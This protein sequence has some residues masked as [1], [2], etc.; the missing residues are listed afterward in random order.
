MQKSNIID[1]KQYNHTLMLYINST[2][3]LYHELKSGILPLTD[4][5]EQINMNKKAIITTHKK[6]FN[7]WQ[8][9]KTGKWYS[10]LPKE[11]VKPPKGKQIESVSEEKLNDKIFDYYTKEEENKQKTCP[12][13]SDVYWKWRKIKDLELGGTSICGYNTNWKRCFEYTDFAEMEIDKINENTVRLFMLSRI[14]ELNLPKEACRKLFDV[15]KHVIRYARVEK[16]ILENPV[17]FLEN[18]DFTKL[19]TDKV[20]PENE[21][22]FNDAELSII[23]NALNAYH[24]ENPLNMSSYAIHLAVF[25][26]MRTGEL[27]TLKWSDIENGC[28]S[29]NKSCKY[30]SLTH[31]FSVGDTKTKKSRKYPLDNQTKSLFE[32]IK[33]VQMQH[34]ILCEW[35]FT[36]GKG[37]YIHTHSV[38]DLMNKLCKR[39]N[40]NGGGVTK[41]RK[42]TSSNLQS[43]GVPKTV[44]ASMLGHTTDVNELYYTYDTSNLDEKKQVVE[45]RNSKFQ[46]MAMAI[47]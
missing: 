33:K 42:T 1:I 17:E 2:K 3:L 10:Y 29:I 30:N 20:K 47:G 44:V 21:C 40:L 18:R 38:T 6:M 11:G 39:N 43:A 19:C 35:I 23:L 15:I 4:I 45:S 7:Y 5:Q 16:L 37:S 46:K 12:T 13:F 9:T 24:K 41:L 34:G 25:T 31:E 27:C 32:Q 36:D 26:G 22:Y 8:N 28:I 14:R